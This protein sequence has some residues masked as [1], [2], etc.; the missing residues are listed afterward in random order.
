MEKKKFFLTGVLLQMGSLPRQNLIQQLSTSHSERMNFMAYMMGHRKNG[1]ILVF[2]TR[3]H[4][5]CNYLGKGD[6][7]KPHH[8]FTSTHCGLGA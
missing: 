3:V 5:A 1:R 7:E 6:A 2:T 8:Q 4:S